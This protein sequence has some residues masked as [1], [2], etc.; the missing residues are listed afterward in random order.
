MTGDQTVQGD[1]KEFTRRAKD[2]LGEDSRF[3]VDHAYR[4]VDVDEQE[5]V[6]NCL[7]VDY[8]E[9]EFF[10]YFGADGRCRVERAEG[11][12]TNTQIGEMDA[13]SHPAI[14]CD[15][16]AAILDR[17]ISPP[18]TV[19]YDGDQVVP[20]AGTADDDPLPSDLRHA[21]CGYRM[22]GHQTT[23]KL[24]A[25]HCQGCGLRIVVPVTVKTWG[26]LRTWAEQKHA[27]GVLDYLRGR[28]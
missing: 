18:V 7:A 6:P 16:L 28:V 4:L 11:R 24:Q 9:R 2:I 8:L 5:R 3:E 14:L 12:S 20:R 10:I 25:Y 17:D 23:K 13:A 27:G 1:A 19:N 22:E 26:D 15:Q 21:V